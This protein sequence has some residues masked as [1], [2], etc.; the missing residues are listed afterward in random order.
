MRT[1]RGDKFDSG[2]ILDNCGTTLLTQHACY[3][4]CAVRWQLDEGKSQSRGPAGAC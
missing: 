2:E 3:T 4:V 1:I